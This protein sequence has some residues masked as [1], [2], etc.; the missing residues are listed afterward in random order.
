MS[1]P[2]PGQESASRQEA[3]LRYPQAWPRM[4]RQGGARAGANQRR[5][6]VAAASGAIP[7][8]EAQAGGASDTGMREPPWR[9]RNASTGFEGDVAIVELRAR[10]ALAPDH[11]PEPVMRR[12]QGGGWSVASRLACVAALA[13]G[14]TFALHGLYAP[15]GAGPARALGLVEQLGSSALQGTAVSLKSDSLKSDSP[16]RDSLK[17]DLA[18]PPQPVPPQWAGRLPAWPAAGYRPPVHDSTIDAALPA[19][20]TVDIEVP[21]A[22]GAEI[23]DGENKAGQTETQQRALPPAAAAPTVNRDEIAALVARGAK[24]FV[25]GDIAAARSVLRPAAL[26][27]DSGAALAL[28][29]TYDPVI[30]KRL[31]VVGLPGDLTEARSWY[32]KAADLGS[33]AAPQRLDQLAGLDR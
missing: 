27:G 4:Q 20:D 15:Q 13:G 30:L 9:R 14:A 23:H 18:Q 7:A 2:V 3:S 31:G 28:G 16:T 6:P 24:Y 29:E 8:Y 32:R 17:R 26:A 10:L 25:A 12:A 19:A 33:T 21:R 1:A 22:T 5:P 11:I